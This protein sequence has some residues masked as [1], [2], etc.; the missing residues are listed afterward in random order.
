M[1][2][3]DGLVVQEAKTQKENKKKQNNCVI[4]SG[5]SEQHIR[6]EDIAC[7]PEPNLY[8][9]MEEGTTNLITMMLMPQQEVH[10][11][12]HCPRNTDSAVI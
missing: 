9:W 3:R 2:C 5:N 4:K 11:G 10:E 8:E 1:K 7:D 6:K 12:R